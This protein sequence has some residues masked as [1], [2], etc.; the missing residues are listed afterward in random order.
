MRAKRLVITLLVVAFFAIAKVATTVY[1]CSSHSD[2]KAEQSDIISRSNYLTDKLVTSPQGVIDM[3]PNITDVQFQGEWALYSCS[4]FS[5]ALVNISRLYPQTA[6]QNRQNIA[7]LID[8]VCSREIR[9]YDSSRWGESALTSLD[10]DNSHISYLS[11]LAWM[12]CGYK[13]AGGGSKYDK[14]LDDICEAMNRRIVQ[15]QACNLPTY[16][17]EPI[18]IPDMLVAI[19]ALK[20]YADMNNGLY[21]TTVDS[22]LE[23]AKSDWIDSDSGLLVSFLNY[24][25][26]QFANAPVK[27]SYSALSCYYLTLVDEQFALEQYNALKQHLWCDGLIAG[28]KEQADG[29]MFDIDIDAGPILFGLSPSGTAFYTGAATY[30]GDESVRNAILRTAEI[31]GTT[32]GFGDSRHYMLANVAIVGEAI[33][34]C[35]RTNK[36]A[37]E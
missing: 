17:G 37:I 13:L 5:S 7:C 12:I 19:V 25:G 21:R 1:H 22:W 8:I 4:M 9:R 24:D 29:F 33:M 15:S 36:R 28:V 3:M 16:P 30:F 31:A 14:L 20:Q 10:G 18:Y 26:S 27:G 23:R 35:M 32:I 6:E 34:L 11:H 2:I